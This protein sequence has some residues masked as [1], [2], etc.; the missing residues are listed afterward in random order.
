MPTSTIKVS[1]DCSQLVIETSGDPIISVTD[2][3]NGRQVS[4]MK[5]TYADYTMRRKAEVLKYKS[6][7]NIN[8]KTYYSY[9]SKTGYYSQ[10]ALKSSINKPIICNRTSTSSASGVVGSNTIYY[11]D[12]NVPYYHSI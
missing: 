5:F 7:V 4:F 8:K 10:G 1:E 12:P 6:A 3:N 2:R 9:L 11:L